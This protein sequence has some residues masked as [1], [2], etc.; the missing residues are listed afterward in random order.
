MRG[1][2]LAAMTALAACG[3]GGGAED[4]PD[5]T[6]PAVTYVTPSNNAA[7]AGTNSRLT[8]TF[9]EPMSAP[10][11]AAAIV[12]ADAQT[13]APVALGSVAYDAANRIATVTPQQPLAPSREYRAT[14]TSAARDT[15]GNAITSDYAWAFGTAAGADTTPPAVSSHSPADGAAG[16]AL[17]ARIAMSFSEPM[18]VASVEAAFVLT[19]GT[20]VVPGRLAYVGQAAVFTPDA[21]LAPQASYVATLRRTATDLAGNAPAADYAWSFTTGAAADTAPPSVLAVTPAPDATGVP[22]DTPLSVTFSEPIYPFVYG[23][24]DGVVVAVAIDY[25]TNTVRVLPNQPLRSSG[26]Y[27]ASILATDVARNAMAAPYQWSFVTAP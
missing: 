3:G 8:V 2:L 1:A 17:N 22:R 7:G 4:A 6:A 20:T 25:D 9:S 13:G 10:S 11:L 21:P 23:K 27:A 5:T 24:I 18:D 26:G 16:V 19:R 12:L 15:S 14:V